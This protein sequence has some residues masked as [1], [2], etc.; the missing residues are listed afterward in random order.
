[1]RARSWC[2]RDAFPDL[3]RGMAVAEE[4]HDYG[5]ELVESQ[6]AAP[7]ATT[8]ATARL[9]SRMS[10][11]AAVAE[12]PKPTNIDMATGEVLSDR[13]ET[14]EAQEPADPIA[15]LLL[16][17]NEAQ[18]R[19]ALEAHRPAVAELKNGL[20]RRAVTAWIA[21]EERIAAATAAL[22]PPY[23]PADV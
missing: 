16:L 13:P 21:A 15:D 17:I 11:Q 14:G 2:L 1:M 3:L 7:S 19:A 4:V 12:L 22:A 20:K 9:K 5:A 8:S 10:A 6:P 18:T 23:D